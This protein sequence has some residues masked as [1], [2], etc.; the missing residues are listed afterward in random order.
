M[1]VQVLWTKPEPSELTAYQ[2]GYADLVPAGD[3][4]LLLE[5]SASKNS[6]LLSSLSPE[7]LKYR[8]AEGKWS[9]PQILVHVTDTERIFAYR[10]LCIAR[11]DKTPLPGYEQDDYAKTCNADQR[12]FKDIVEE[13][14]HVRKATISLL[15]SLDPKQLSNTGIAN[16]KEVSVRTLCYILAGHEIHHVNVMI[17]KYLK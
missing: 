12:D 13:F 14:N 3:L 5:N 8:Y 11:G 10:I 9:I 7:K 15:K 16:T 2:R 6:Q 17:E 1:P 4:P